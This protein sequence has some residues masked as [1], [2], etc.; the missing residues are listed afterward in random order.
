MAAALA[1]GLA[2]LLFGLAGCGG[3]DD[4]S[5]G[6]A[7]DTPTAG[8][9]SKTSAADGKE[10]GDDVDLTKLPLGDGYIS[11]E[12]AVDNVYSC[13]VDFP[14]NAGGSLVDGPWI[15][16]EQGTWNAE[17]K[18]TVPGEIFEPSEFDVEVKGD[19][20]EI[21]GNDLPEEPVGE[22]PVG[23]ETE[24][25]KYDPNPNEIA[26]QEFS[27]SLPAVP[28]PADEAACL[29]LGAVGVLL[30]GGYLINALDGPGRDAV[31][32]EIQDECDGHP[33]RTGAYHYHSLSSCIEDEPGDAHSELVGYA[34]DGFGI[35]GH[36]GE[37]G[38]VL[39]N[40]DLDECHGHTHEV[41]WDGEQLEIY[42]YHST[43]EYPYTVG[44]YRGTPSEDEDLGAGSP[45][46]GGQQGFAAGPPEG[47]PAPP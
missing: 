28:E 20:R 40:D 2:A 5:E 12:P 16:A 15:D 23:S 27:L 17:E 4:S 31:A 45:D 33:E 24:A 36:H 11:T 18:V 9:E 30:D 22:F 37:D 25:Y 41:E 13:Q 34:I 6:Q 32:H 39:S 1:A 14:D 46:Q 8:G 19:A 21:T 3:G 35:Y 26:A 44:C 42:H 29:S 38:E 10:P 7:A 43:F 47:G